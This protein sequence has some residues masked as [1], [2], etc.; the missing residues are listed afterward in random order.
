MCSMGILKASHPIPH[1][2]ATEPVALIPMLSLA[3]VSVPRRSDKRR[4]SLE[5]VSQHQTVVFR[6]VRVPPLAAQNQS[7][8]RLRAAPRLVGL[9]QGLF[10][11]Q[12]GAI[13]DLAQVDRRRL[14]A[15]TLEPF[16]IG[17]MPVDDI[18]EV[19]NHLTDLLRAL[20]D[21][22]QRQDFPVQDLQCSSV[23]VILASGEC[24]S[25]DE[26]VGA[27]KNMLA[28]KALLTRRSRFRV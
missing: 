16:P 25:H 24:F 27:V 22:R 9:L 2:N 12:K 20:L 5:A 21:G 28:S 14:N 8:D 4:Q 13:V 23:V 17:P 7:C 11:R 6:K 3:A 26:L 18:L 19:S 10:D 15:K 1:T